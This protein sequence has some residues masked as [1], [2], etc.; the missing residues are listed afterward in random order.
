MEVDAIPPRR[1]RSNVSCGFSPISQ[2]GAIRWGTESAP[3]RHLGR[4]GARTRA[5]APVPLDLR[6]GTCWGSLKILAPAARKGPQRAPME[7][8]RGPL[9]IRLT[10]PAITPTRSSDQK[11]RGIV[12]GRLQSASPIA[13]DRRAGEGSRGVGIG[14]TFVREIRDGI[15]KQIVA[16][17]SLFV[18]FWYAP[19]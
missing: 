1:R 16:A 18:F 13:A 12:R 6:A 19:L 10:K 9:P 8:C 14:G 11:Q 4:C 17:A 5:A 3:T 15:D 2:R 7:R